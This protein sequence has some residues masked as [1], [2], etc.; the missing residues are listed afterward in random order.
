MYS[1][2]QHLCSCGL[3]NQRRKWTSSIL[4][5]CVFTLMSAGLWSAAAVKGRTVVA[6]NFRRNGSLEIC[7]RL[8]IKN[9]CWMP[10]C[11]ESCRRS[12]W[13]GKTVSL[14]LLS[15]LQGSKATPWCPLSTRWRRCTTR[16]R[17]SRWTSSSTR[18]VRAAARPTP[19]PWK[20]LSHFHAKAGIDFWIVIQKTVALELKSRLLTCKSAVWSPALAA[21][22][23]VLGK[24]W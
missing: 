13:R 7:G 2:C 18:C 17:W 3:T 14:P 23:G 20:V 15:V 22:P 1:P 16:S 9:G 4:L 8:T 21:C 10:T 6:T 11:T 24:M 12:S 5:M 19:K